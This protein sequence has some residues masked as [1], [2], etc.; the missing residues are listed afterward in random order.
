LVIHAFVR[1]PDGHFIT[2]EA[3]GAGSGPNQGTEVA[4]IN[5]EGTIVGVWIDSNGAYH[6]FIRTRAGALK[7]FD[8]PNAGTGMGQGIIPSATTAL[9]PSGVSTGQYVDGK[10]TYHGYVRQ[11]AGA[12]T[13]FDPP[14]STNTLAEG[15]NPEGT[16]VGTFGDKNNVGHAFVRNAHGAI[17]TFDV[18]GALNN[19]NA[20]DITPYGVITGLWNDSND[21]Y[22][23]FVRYANGVILKFDVPGAGA[24]PGLK[25]G[26]IPLAINCWGEITGQIQASFWGSDAET[27]IPRTT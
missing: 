8:A 27:P 4:D 14:G 15:I 25:Q 3:P 5:S 26:T 19:T 1:E 22:H 18:P 23:G 11:R 10:G 9:G 16:I 21:V 24:V 20:R 13:S 17:N 6:G 12:I 7:S 2:F